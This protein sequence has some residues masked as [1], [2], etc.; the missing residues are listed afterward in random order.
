MERCPTCGST[1]TRVE[2]LTK[3]WY[4][5][6]GCGACFSDLNLAGGVRAGE[7]RAPHPPGA[8][9]RTRDAG[10]PTGPAQ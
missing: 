9:H 10:G 7:H 1:L 4:C 2:G 8:R 6:D 5:A 3:V